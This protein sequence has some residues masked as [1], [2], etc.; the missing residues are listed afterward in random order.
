M[1]QKSL[2]KK[3]GAN[4]DPLVLRKVRL[5]KRKN[6]KMEEKVLLV[7]GGGEKNAGGG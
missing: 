4:Y 3:A 5:E 7:I 6:K 1:G 2:Q